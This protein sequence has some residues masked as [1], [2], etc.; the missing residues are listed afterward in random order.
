MG[1]F[2]WLGDLF[3]GKPNQQDLQSYLNRLNKKKSELEQGI[4]NTNRL[5]DLNRSYLMPVLEK[6]LKKGCVN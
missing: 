5:L 6:M 2:S 1:I 3:F 4:S